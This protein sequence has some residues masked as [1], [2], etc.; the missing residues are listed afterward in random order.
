MTFT[1]NDFDKYPFLSSLVPKLRDNTYINQP[2][3]RFIESD[4]GKEVLKMTQGRISAAL[5]DNGDKI[6][7]SN[8]LKSI[9]SYGFARMVV[10]LMGEDAIN[11]FVT[12][13][14]NR[15]YLLFIRENERRRAEIEKELGFSLSDKRIPLKDYIP[16]ATNLIRRD[17]RFRLVNMP[18]SKGF[19]SVKDNDRELIFKE[20]IR[21]KL[22]RN[23]PVEI[24]DDAHKILDPIAS[25]LS[26]SYSER[27]KEYYGEVTEEN[28][29]PCM[30]HVI[31]VI[32]KRENPTHYGRFALVSFCNAIGMQESQI[33]SMFQTAR[34]FEANTTQ[35]MV[36]HI[37]GKQGGP[38]YKPPACAGL[39]TNNICRSGDDPL[40]NKVKHPLGYYAALKKRKII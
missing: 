27:F 1:L 7:C 22:K 24:K 31:D 8:P 35:Y 28:F 37:L 20:R 32:K 9:A 11:R 30:N 40:C 38:K 33:M 10:S 23:L 26:E 16:A 2:L 5:G 18:V 3:E 25:G 19:V 6:I 34:D 17:A 14:A 39:K 13:E 12:S 21:L 4:D 29:P 36:G 15:S